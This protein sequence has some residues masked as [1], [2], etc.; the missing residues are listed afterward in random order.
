MNLFMLQ[1]SFWAPRA[2]PAGPERGPRRP[3][4]LGAAPLGNLENHW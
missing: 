2:A 1:P 4:P 3:S